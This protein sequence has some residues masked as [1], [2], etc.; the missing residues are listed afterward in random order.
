MGRAR[1]FGSGHGRGMILRLSLAH[2]V[3]RGTF[4]VRGHAEFEMRT[5]LKT[6]RGKIR[7]SSLRA[8]C[9]GPR[10]SATSPFGGGR[11]FCWSS[12]YSPC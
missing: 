10:S 9:V 8:V 11:C 3:R 1:L 5:D 4:D 6:E 2:D 7:A 12:K